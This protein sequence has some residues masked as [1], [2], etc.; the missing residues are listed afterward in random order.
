MVVDKNSVVARQSKTKAKSLYW[1]NAREYIYIRREEVVEQL[2]TFDR[3]YNKSTL[4]SAFVSEYEH[5]KIGFGVAT[6]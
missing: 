6:F 2:I 1:S 5:E 4:D 3:I